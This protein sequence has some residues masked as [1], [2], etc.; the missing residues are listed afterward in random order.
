MN[1]AVCTCTSQHD[2]GCYSN[3]ETQLT[4]NVLY[5][6]EV[7]FILDPAQTIF[8]KGDNLELKCSG[9]GNPDP[10]LTLTTKEITENLT[11]VQTTELTHTLT[12]DCM[13]TG[14]YV[15]SG[16]NSQGTNRTE[17][18]IG[19]RCQQQLSPLFNSKLQVDAVNGETAKFG[20]EIYG[21]PQPSTLTLQKTDDDTNLASS[22]RHSVEYTAGVSSFGVV[23]VTISDVVEADYTNYTLTVDNG[24][25]NALIYTFYLN[26]VNA[27]SA[28]VEIIASKEDSLNI[29]AIVI[30]VIAVAIIA[31]LIVVIIFLLK[32]I[33]GLKKRLDSQCKIALG[34]NPQTLQDDDYLI[35]LAMS[36]I[37]TPVSASLP[38]RQGQY[39]TV[40]DKPAATPRTGQYETIQDM[41]ATSGTYNS[42][43]RQDVEPVSVYQDVEPNHLTSGDLGSCGPYSNVP[44]THMENLRNPAANYANVDMSSAKR[45]SLNKKVTKQTYQNVEMK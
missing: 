43:S 8:S 3:N 26:E 42:T 18:S 17:I 23:N 9:Q 33:R 34:S 5:V 30:G 22:S 2:S 6:P 1:G 40:D 12:L 45:N 14:V 7:T 41:T 35:P 39:E 28:W 29:V 44:G 10:T 20:I 19:V 11:N 24:V 16:Q 13:D 25:G 31:G 37:T 32:K 36:T 4:I 27:S 21:F 38:P 15:C